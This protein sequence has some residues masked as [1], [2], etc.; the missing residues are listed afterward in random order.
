MVYLKCF[1]CHHPCLAAAPLNNIYIFYF[2]LGPPF[3]SYWCH[4]LSPP[5][6]SQRGVNLGTRLIRNWAVGTTPWQ[7]MDIF[8]VYGL[9][10]GRSQLPYAGVSIPGWLWALCVHDAAAFTSSQFQHSFILV[11]PSTGGL[12][13]SW[14]TSSPFFWQTLKLRNVWFFPSSSCH[15]QWVLYSLCTMIHSLCDSC[16]IPLCA[17]FFKYTLI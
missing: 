8:A 1:S 9:S 11:L 4:R 6:S 5:F 2:F 17:T 10:R 12:G 3:P 14:G 7:S 15:L 13:I 16:P